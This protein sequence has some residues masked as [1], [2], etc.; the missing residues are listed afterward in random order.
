MSGY[1]Y[2]P[3]VRIIP[4]DG[5]ETIYDLTTIYPTAAG[6]VSSRVGYEVL[7]AVR[8]SPTRR[9][10]ARRW[11]YLA[12]VELAFEIS[13]LTD[14]PQ[15]ADLASALM[16]NGTEVYFSTNGGTNERRV[17]ADSTYA[18]E[19]LA[20]KAAAGVAVSFRLIASDRFESIP[21]MVDA[22]NG[23]SAW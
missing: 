8:F 15:L 17:I 11:G 13:L 9:I 5:P 3:R 7:Q 14:E 19:P 10:L 12:W 1:S 18:R 20:G 23:A 2:R 16:T 21:T 6:A 4:A 22:A